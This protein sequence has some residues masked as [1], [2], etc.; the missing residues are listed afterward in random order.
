VGAFPPRVN[1]LTLESPNGF[2]V[3]FRERK[4]RFTAPTERWIPLKISGWRIFFTVNTALARSFHPVTGCSPV[5]ELDSS[6]FSQ[7]PHP[8]GPLPA[9][10]RTL[11]SSSAPYENVSGYVA[12]ARDRGIGRWFLRARPGVVSLLPPESPS[13]FPLTRAFPLPLAH[14]TE[15]SL[16]PL[17]VRGQSAPRLDEFALP[18]CT[19]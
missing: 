12:N 3:P 17:W 1:A 6:S 7:R 5:N 2:R 14:L 10:T 13:A 8:L 19:A 16:P 11:P 15:A 9:P 18:S 4:A